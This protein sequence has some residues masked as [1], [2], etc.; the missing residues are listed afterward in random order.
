MMM[1]KRGA[2]G[3]VLGASLLIALT[4]PHL[5]ATQTA[6][7]RYTLDPSRSS[8]A[9]TFLQAGARNQ[10]R[11]LRFTA[12]LDAPDSPSNGRLDV[13]VDVRSLDTGD[14]DR[15]DTLRGPDFFDVGQFS[16]AHFAANRID[17]TPKGYQAVGKLTLRGISRDVDVPFTLK[18][19]QEQGRTIMYLTG[20][21][22]IRRLDFGVGQGEWKSTQW[23][24][25]DV[26]LSYSLRLL[27]R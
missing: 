3:R 5:G 15:D 2:Y 1:R 26:E 23:V 24:G 13:T 20:K 27:P 25:S 16:G 19:T 21:T 11:F 22:T 8:L 10:G 9:F 12:A 7:I 18:T 6:A 14:K 17:R 4:L